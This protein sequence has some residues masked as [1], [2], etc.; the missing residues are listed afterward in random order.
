[1]IIFYLLVAIMPLVQHPIWS[2]TKLAGLTLN[3]YVGILTLLVAVWDFLSNRRPVHPFRT[4][5][6]RIFV[7]FA[8]V[9]MGS[10]LIS[11]STVPIGESPFGN[12][13]SFLLLFVATSVLLTSR[14]RLCWVLLCAVGGVA[15]A[16]LHLIREWQSSGMGTGVRPGWITGDP[17]YF[18]VSALLCL[19]LGLVLAQQRPV[20]WERMFYMAC[21]AVTL[22][23]LTLAGSRGGFLG[24][25]ISGVVLAWSS[26]RRVQY[27]A[28]GALVVGAVMILAPTSPMARLFNPNR[29]DQ[30]S[31][32][33]HRALLF[34]GIRMFEDNFWTGVGAGNF[35]PLVPNYLDPGMKLAAVAHNTYLEVGAEL[36][37]GGLLTFVAMLFFSLRTLWRLQ[38]QSRAGRDPLIYAT[39]RGIGAGLLGACVAIFFVSA[40]H[41]RLLWF[42][43]ILSMCLPSLM[44]R[45]RFSRP[46]RHSKRPVSMPP[47]DPPGVE[48]T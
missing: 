47:A 37:I 39:A 20:R 30:E 29:S 19:P 22:I 11:G 44:L 35:K 41:A 9:M 4:I 24:L 21:C 46:P 38:R 27:L 28:V 23:A 43:A 1:M 14:R 45:P 33:E 5:Q 40:L 10:F 36:G 48:Q 34:A 42:M 26:R 7:I 31:T 18:A 8:L 17:N 2:E 25:L 15:F 13:S 32:D 16:S 3:K 12:W 6:S